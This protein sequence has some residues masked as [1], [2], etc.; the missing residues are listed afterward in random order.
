MPFPRSRHHPVTAARPRGGL[1][2]A[3]HAPARRVPALLALATLALASLAPAARVGAQDVHGGPGYLFQFPTGSFTVRGGFQAPMAGSDLFS[4]A[5]SL[6]TLRRRDFG[7]FSGGLD[8]SGFMTP[9]L[10]LSLGL[11]VERRT[12][13]SEYRKWEFD[14][15]SPIR[16]RTTFERTPILLSVRWYP[17]APGDQI[18][19]F[20]WIPRRV[21]PFVGAGVGAMHYTFQQ[22]GDFVDFDNGNRVFAS[23][24][25]S[26]GWT[27]AAGAS[28]GVQVSLTRLAVLTTQVRT[29]WSRAPLGRDFRGF[30]PIDLSGLSL[31]TGLTIR[32]P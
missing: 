16:Q 30:Q 10:E 9:H 21:V 18:G 22:E 26:S 25:T 1:A 31:T 3:R 20:A 28:A 15:G 23:Q 27:W 8:V 7:G 6:L 29:T 5:T 13:G 11:D 4:D 12:A 14:D 17:V 19:R 2:S 32:V 24:L